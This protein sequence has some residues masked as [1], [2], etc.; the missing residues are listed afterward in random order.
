[1]RID[2]DTYSS[3]GL[4]SENKKKLTLAV[5]RRHSKEEI[6]TIDLSKYTNA[7]S[8][9][10][11]VY[12][13]DPMGADFAFNASSGILTVKLPKTNSARFFEINN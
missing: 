5:W 9:A 1:M 3:L 7:K 13:Q 6:I 10:K 11:L 8:T 12:P 4:I 2:D